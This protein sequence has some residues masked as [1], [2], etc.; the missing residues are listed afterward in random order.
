MTR[1]FALEGFTDFPEGLVR[2]VA[3]PKDRPARE[4]LAYGAYLSGLTLANGGLGIAHGLAAALGV[5]NQISHGLACA[6]LLP[7][8]LKLNFELCVERLAVVGRLWKGS[9]AGGDRVDAEFVLQ[10]VDGLLTD[11]EVPKRLRELGVTREQIP[12]LV[13]G[14]HGNSRRGNPILLDDELIR[15]ELEMML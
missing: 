7:L 13:T 2:V 11:L 3:N 9:S 5:Q 15:R 10:T 8:A 12:D 1:A 6:V 14:S 4:R